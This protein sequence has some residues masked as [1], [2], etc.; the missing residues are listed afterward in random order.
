MICSK[1][2]YKL[3]RSKLFW[4]SRRNIESKVSKLTFRHYRMSW[5]SGRSRSP[6]GLRGSEGP[7]AVSDLEI[8]IS[9]QIPATPGGPASPAGPRGFRKSGSFGW[10]RKSCSNFRTQKLSW[11]VRFGRSGRS[12]C[13]HQYSCRY[14]SE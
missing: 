10:F 5:R 6:E 1:S 14:K 9:S 11:P 7:G 2:V 13:F 3:H 8:T 4:C 12:A